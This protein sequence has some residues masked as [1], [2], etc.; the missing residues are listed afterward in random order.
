MFKL[1]LIVIMGSSLAVAQNS[2]NQTVNVN[3]CACKPKVE[4]R[5]R[6]KTKTVVKHVPE[7]I[8]RKK[9][10]K[11]PGPVR[12]KT[13][14]VIRRVKEKRPL[15]ALSI[16]VSRDYVGLDQ[17]SDGTSIH[18]K[19]EPEVGIGLMYQRS[20]GPVRLSIGGNSNGSGYLGAGLEF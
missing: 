1:L 7:V 3:S 6:W 11:V 17:H 15:N 14:R 10:V 13:K 2:C 16:M 18:A 20:V 4:Y 9:I 12:V 8:V 19:T 5:T